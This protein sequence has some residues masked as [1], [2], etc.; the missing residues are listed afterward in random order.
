MDAERL[1]GRVVTIIGTVV[2]VINIC[3]LLSSAWVTNRWC[4]PPVVA[5]LLTEWRQ[6]VKFL[7]FLAHLID[8]LIMAFFVV[9]GI[10]LCL[11]YW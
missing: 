4:G 5:L 1:P 9:A 11:K 10:H 6:I 8:W 3:I 2:V 7:T